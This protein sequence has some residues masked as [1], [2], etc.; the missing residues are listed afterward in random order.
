MQSSADRI[1][2]REGLLSAAQNKALER[3]APAAECMFLVIA[4][5]QQVTD[6]E[7]AALRGAIRGLAGDVLSD[8]LLV[9]MMEKFALRLRD[10]GVDAR[11]TAI[12]RGLE[13]EESQSVFGL[14]AAAALADNQV[15]DEEG[16]VLEKLKSA[17]ELSDDAVAAILGE[18]ES[19]ADA[20][21][22]RSQ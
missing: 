8:E 6:T 18:L 16:S 17:L 2:A 3:V 9:M 14:A 20:G 1:L 19:D 22:T 15:A 11:L 4:A 10:E 5:D 13:V 12:A 7:L 21:P